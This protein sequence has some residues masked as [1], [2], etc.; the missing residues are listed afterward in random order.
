M[1]GSGPMIGRHLHLNRKGH[2]LFDAM[3]AEDSM[4]VDRRRALGTNLAVN[5]VGTKTDL[6]ILDTFKDFF[7]HLSIS[8]TVAAVCAGRIDHQ[9]PANLAGSRIVAHLSMLQSKG[10]MDCVH[11]ITEGE[12]NRGLRGLEVEKNT[13]SLR[14]ASASDKQ[15]KL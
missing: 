3:D 10:P 6:W 11:G 9:F 4:H 2:F 8:H 15:Y 12:A 5:V 14:N 7:M 13:G 1:S